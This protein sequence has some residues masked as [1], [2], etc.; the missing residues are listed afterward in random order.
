M[1]KIRGVRF[2]EVC[3]GLRVRR[4]RF[5][6]LLFEAKIREVRFGEVRFGLRV[7]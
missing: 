2:G 7:R 1:A 4:V 5:S 3:F 6:G